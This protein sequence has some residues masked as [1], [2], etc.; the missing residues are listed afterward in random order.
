[1]KYCSQCPGNNMQNVSL[2]Q[3]NIC[4]GFTHQW[5]QQLYRNKVAWKQRVPRDGACTVVLLLFFCLHP[6]D[7]RDKGQKKSGEFVSF[8]MEETRQRRE[9]GFLLL[10]GWRCRTLCLYRVDL[11]LSSRSFVSDLRQHDTDQKL[12]ISFLK[13]SKLC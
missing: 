11:C 1:M 5:I 6:R 8:T 10:W 3:W 9:R 12:V 7:E 4:M 13:Y 2:I